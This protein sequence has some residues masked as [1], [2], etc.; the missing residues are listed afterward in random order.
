MYINVIRIKNL[1]KKVTLFTLLFAIFGSSISH[2]YTGVT[3]ILSA[4][5]QTNLEFV[6][7]FKDELI[8]SKNTALRVTMIDLHETDQLV[9]AE[10]SELVI[11]LGVNALE[12][13]SKLKHT[14]PVIGV[15][16]PLPAFN[17]LLA[18]SKR[19]L[20]N[21]SSIVLDQPY[22]RQ[23]VL[24]KTIM[25][26]VRNLGVLLGKSSS[27]YA[28]LI[29]E[30][31]EKVA[32]NVNAENIVLD[33]DL[34]PKLNKILDSNDALMAIPDPLVYSRETAQPILLTTYRHQKPVFGYSR[35]YVQAGALAAV[36]SSTKQLAKQATEIAVKS[37]AAPGLLPPPQPPKYFSV[38]VNYQVA[39]SFNM[40]IENVDK[41][42]KKIAEAELAQYEN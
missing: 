39:R 37:Q 14:T 16:T 7:H 18:A 21:F 34:I 26:N 27:Q 20:G 29:K 12:A 33:A 2:A 32:I 40:A 28:E 42:Q 1:L 6:E 4:P 15:F 25:P 24:I 31:G 22:M 36:Y 5:T 13:A 19:D 3:I 17:R 8:S 10:N 38:A 9:V 11:A 35:S 23:M 30:T 41:L